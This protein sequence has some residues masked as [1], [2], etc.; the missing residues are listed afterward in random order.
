VDYA[1]DTSTGISARDRALT[2]RKLADPKATA[3]EFQRPGH[4]FPLRYSP[5]GVMTRRGHTEAAVD[6]ARLAGRF[7]AGVLCELCNDDGTMS[8]LPELEEFARRHDLVL[9]SIADLVAYLQDK[10]R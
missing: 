5:G 3:A 9:T 6:L 4:I 10:D 8:R 2:L 7:P 1:L